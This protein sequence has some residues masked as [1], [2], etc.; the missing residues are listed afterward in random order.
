[1]CFMSCPTW[2]TVKF[3][4]VKAYLIC[5]YIYLLDLWDE[6]YEATKEAETR[7]CIKKVITFDI[8]YR[9]LIDSFIAT[10]HR[11]VI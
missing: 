3:D 7:V 10:P 4:L 11:Y 8:Y 9:A 2:W 6:A 5:N 1:M